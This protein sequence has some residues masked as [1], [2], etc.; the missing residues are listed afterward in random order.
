MEL[1]WLEDFLALTAR[2]TFSRAAEARNVTQ[3][4]F[5][6]RIRSLESW[7]GADLFERTGS[8]V[9][10]TRAGKVF[11]PGAEEI[12]RRIRRLAHDVQEAG[13]KADA[14]LL[15]AATHALSFTFLPKWI[16]DLETHGPLGPLTLISDS[17]QG[18]EKR[19][20][21]GDA[22]FLL[23]HAAA[24]TPG[25]LGSSQFQS[26]VVGADRL[27]PFSAPSPGGDPLWSLDDASRATPFLAYSPESGLGR[28][29]GAT[30]FREGAPDALDT[31]F[32][33]HLA[34][35][36]LSLTRDGR[37]VCWLPRALS[38]QDIAAG[39][40]VPASRNPAWSM[41]MD[42][43]LFRPTARQTEPAEAFWT[44]VSEHSASS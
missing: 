37:G 39:R 5:S 19:M 2:G 4:A 22:Q 9:A 6:R 1:I 40:I 11:L 20:I 15:V 21:D 28:I 7:L 42:V 33:S 35:T 36:L 38:E 32:T 25:P 27:E 10:L 43:R 44:R 8:G 12:V 14:T 23:C 17:L 26:L 41:E 31:V 16:R 3:P 34:A 30:L 18:C 13:G 29:L 24:E